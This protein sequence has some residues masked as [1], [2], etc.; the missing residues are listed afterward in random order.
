MNL[1]GSFL[2]KDGLEGTFA[3][4]VEKNAAGRTAVPPSLAA[5]IPSTASG[6]SPA[7]PASAFQ[8][9]LAA[10]QET[11]SASAPKASKK[12]AAEPVGSPTV[13]GVDR[14]QLAAALALPPPQAAPPSL[15]TPIEPGASES[16]SASK[17]PVESP[18]LSSSFAVFAGG[19]MEN[20]DPAVTPEP[21]VSSAL[22]ELEAV[23][24]AVGPED[25]PALPVGLP[26]SSTPAAAPSSPPA[27][28][29]PAAPEGA[30]TAAPLASPVPTSSSAPQAAPPIPAPAALATSVPSDLVV[31]TAAS[32]L[33]APVRA[34][35]PHEDARRP[36]S[37]N[38]Q[39]GTP[40]ARRAMPD[41]TDT[42]D[43]TAPGA[44][45]PSMEKTAA[46]PAEPPPST[47]AEA[48]H[49]G[50]KT[51]PRADADNVSASTPDHAPQASLPSKAEVS[52]PVSQDPTNPAPASP[53]E[54]LKAASSP[55]RSN[56]S[57]SESKTAVEAS[58]ARPE[59]V[60]QTAPTV[61]A[62]TSAKA[63]P[64]AE[65]PL[66]A[67]SAPAETSATSSA[68]NQQVIRGAAHGVIDL[69]DLGR[70]QVS[71]KSQDGDVGVRVTADRPETT[72]ILLP[73]AE[74]MAAEARTPGTLNVRVEVESRSSAQASHTSTAGGGGGESGRHRSPDS[75]PTDEVSEV[76]RAVVRPRVR[77]V[78]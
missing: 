3:A 55:S 26:P 49:G 32:P 37:S 61:N 10:N 41:S 20:H 57:S 74:A 24:S 59:G 36:V 7:P 66:D 58:A 54:N 2:Q 71:A 4:S 30:T 16:P 48:P 34:E 28:T 72:A 47:L 25:P 6:A 68:I 31:A 63:V 50:S 21:N 64:P 1:L 75:H 46:T 35:A 23:P 73:H 12:G 56:E 53:G 51:D 8:S 15:V 38:R 11:L 33:P 40:V 76:D 29:L 17:A 19:T 44:R 18:A 69:P 22:P 42:N 5:P 43:V 65:R 14:F 70:I 52:D 77:I 45:G 39:D 78:L 13:K 67:S 60:G 9:L 62:L 27:P